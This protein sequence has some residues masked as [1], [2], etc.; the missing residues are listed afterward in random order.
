MAENENPMMLCKQHEM[1]QKRNEARHAQ[2]AA[3]R[4]TER[5]RRAQIGGDYSPIDDGGWAPCGT[6]RRRIVHIH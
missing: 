1:L 6:G 3:E 4:E 5:A 2:M